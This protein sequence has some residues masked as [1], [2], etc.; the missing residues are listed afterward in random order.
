[1]NAQE[2]KDLINEAIELVTEAQGLVE[3][4]LRGTDE[5]STFQAYGKFGF[6]QLLGNGNPY[7][8]S[9]PQ[10]AETIGQTEEEKDEYYRNNRAY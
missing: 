8:D 4:A 5:E 2:R 7:D 6:N 9:L 1:M 3:D 10:L